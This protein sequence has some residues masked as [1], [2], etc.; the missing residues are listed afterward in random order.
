[1]TTES[2]LQLVFA[3]LVTLGLIAGF[4]WLLRRFGPLAGLPVRRPGDRRLAVQEVLAIDP[5]RRLMLVRRDGV[6]HLLLIGGASDLVIET[7]IASP[8][9]PPSPRPFKSALDAAQSE[10]P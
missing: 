1:M 3:L 8:G 7:G 6:E 5:R 2:Y 9:A 10:T 4:G